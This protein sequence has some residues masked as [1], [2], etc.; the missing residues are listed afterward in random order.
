MSVIERPALVRKGKQVLFF[1]DV[2]KTFH[3]TWRARRGAKLRENGIVGES[4]VTC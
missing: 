4:M 1:R 3:Q 2:Q